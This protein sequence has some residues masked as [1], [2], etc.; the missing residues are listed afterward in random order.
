MADGAFRKC[1]VCGQ[2]W[3]T[4][5]AFVLDRELTL[6]GLQAAPRTPRANALVF[7]HKSCGSVSVLTYKL[8]GPLGLPDPEP[9]EDGSC[10]G[11]YR[12]LAEL[13]ACDKDCPI[14]PDRKLVGMIQEAR[15]N[16][17]LPSTR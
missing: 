17:S 14:A 9:D 11:C 10:D 1:G 4:W 2:V 8:R 5:Q 6:L 15:R 7:N 16:G 3:M 13:A 12:D